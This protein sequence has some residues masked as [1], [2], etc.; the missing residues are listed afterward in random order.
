MAPLLAIL[1][2]LFAFLISPSL[3][4]DSVGTSLWSSTACTD[5]SVTIPSWIVANFSLRAAITP[6]DNGNGN[7]VAFLIL[8]NRATD[9][10]WY[11][12][13]S[14]V[15]GQGSCKTTKTSGG[16]LSVAVSVNV[17]NKTA[18]VFAN[19]TWTCND[20]L[21]LDKKPAVIEFKAHGSTS[22]GLISDPSSGRVPAWKGNP[23][24]SLIKGSLTSPV[25]L[26]VSY[27]IGPGQMTASNS[28]T[29]ATSPPLWRFEEIDYWNNT[30]S[31]SGFFGPT[32]GTGLNL[33]IVNTRADNSAKCDAYLNLDPFEPP[34][35]TTLQV[36]EDPHLSWQPPRGPGTLATDLFFDPYDYTMR[37]NQT[38]YCRDPI[39]VEVTA[40]TATSASLRPVMNCTTV[41]YGPAPWYGPGQ[42]PSDDLR[43]HCT[44][45]SVVVDGSISTVERLPAFSIEDPR[46]EYG[47]CLVDSLTVPSWSIQE[48]SLSLNESNVK[49]KTATIYLG[50]LTVGRNYIGRITETFNLTDP[51]SWGS[52]MGSQFQNPWGLLPSCQFQY[53]M[54]LNRLTIH[55][56]WICDDKGNGRNIQFNGTGT[57]TLPPRHCTP[58]TN[59]SITCDFGSPGPILIAPSGNVTYWNV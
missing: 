12:S 56:Q 57:V 25:Q 18:Q 51:P 21:N 43:T 28:P 10:S 23:E 42:T 3:A 31:R 8:T 40:V 16:D 11:V 44:G 38:W 36:A 2:S 39:T 5:K 13:C 7:A 55:E 46:P 29:C 20:K 32:R 34:S 33:K 17:V 37:M 35:P 53:D 19:E 58:T 45:S 27:Y 14:L 30:V 49:E 6:T 4:E 22:F 15:Q 47:G 26:E 9:L 41:N 52:C 48:I 54:E 1:L 59:S 50:I 24:L